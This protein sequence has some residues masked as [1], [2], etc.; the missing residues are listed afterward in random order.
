MRMVMPINAVTYIMHV[1]GDLCKFYFMF[2][3]S[4][5][6]KDPPC[7]LR[8]LRRMLLRMLGIPQFVERGIALLDQ[9]VDLLV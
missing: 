4:K 1:S 6:L 8:R 3:T 9:Q 7:R 5:F 2:S